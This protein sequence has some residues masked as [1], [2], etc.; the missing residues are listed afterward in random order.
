M[1]GPRDFKLASLSIMPSASG[2]GQAGTITIANQ[3]FNVKQ[4][5]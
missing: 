4:K 5:Q 3:V 2:A 1:L